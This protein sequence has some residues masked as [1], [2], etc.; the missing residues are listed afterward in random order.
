[1]KLGGEEDREAI[2]RDEHRFGDVADR[3]WRER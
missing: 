2:V 3:T 1:M